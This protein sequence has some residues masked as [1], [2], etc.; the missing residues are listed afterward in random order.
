MI[1]KNIKD[2]GV[3]DRAISW[4]RKKSPWV[5]HMPCG[6]CN[7]CDIEVAACITPRYDIERFG[8]KLM[9]NPRHSDILLVTGTVPAQ[10]KESL[11]RVVSQVPEP[12]VIVAVGT[13]ACSGGIFANDG[14]SIRAPIVNLVDTD[15]K[16]PGC[17]PKPEA[18]IIGAIKAIE[19]LGY[20]NRQNFHRKNEI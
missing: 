11:K 8:M 19:I 12:K 15:I 5:Y 9:N 1:I 14:Y 20:K 6:G 4:A 10:L 13:C 3:I 17:P 2:F 7:G 16:V 18:I